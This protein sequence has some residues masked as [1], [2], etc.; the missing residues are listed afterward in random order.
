MNFDAPG[1]EYEDGEVN[2]EWRIWRVKLFCE[3]L[4]NWHEM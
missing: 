2:V 4:T 3:G 1:A